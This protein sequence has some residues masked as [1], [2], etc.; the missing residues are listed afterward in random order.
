MIGFSVIDSAPT[1]Y[2]IKLIHLFTHVLN[3]RTSAKKGSGRAVAG[4]ADRRAQ[5]GENMLSTLGR[6]G[7]LPRRTEMAPPDVVGR[8]A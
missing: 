1:R 3:L 6:D 5:T 4:W 7:G 2:R 8:L